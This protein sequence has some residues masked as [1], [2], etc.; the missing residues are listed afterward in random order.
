[1]MRKDISNP[2]MYIFIVAFISVY[3]VRKTFLGK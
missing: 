2:D 3:S 1:M